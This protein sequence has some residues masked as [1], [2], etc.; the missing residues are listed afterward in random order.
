[1]PSA[2]HSSANRLHS[3][4]STALTAESASR[5][6]FGTEAAR[7]AT[8]TTTQR[9]VRRARKDAGAM[10]HLRDGH[11]PTLSGKRLQHAETSRQGH[12]EIAIVAELLERIRRERVRVS[13]SRAVDRRGCA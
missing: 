10:R 2:A 13:A 11:V 1:M 8:A 4:T 12:D 5:L 9:I 3:I 7:E 6:G